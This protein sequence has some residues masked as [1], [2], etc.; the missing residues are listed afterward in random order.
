[1]ESHI[2]RIEISPELLVKHL[3]MPD[4]TDILGS[5]VERGVHGHV[6]VLLVEHEDLPAVNEGEV[7]P[8]I[9]PIITYHRESWEFD[10]NADVEHD[11]QM[12]DFD[13][14]DPLDMEPYDS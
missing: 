10:W 8:L 14:P 11:L 9:S 12:D 2:A 4:G 1:M 5:M 7:A 3:H 13:Y 6:V